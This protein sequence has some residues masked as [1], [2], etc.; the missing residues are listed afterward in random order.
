[1]HD[2][3]QRGFGRNARD[4]PAHLF[5]SAMS[6]GYNPPGT[7][8]GTLGSGEE[9]GNAPDFAAANMIGWLAFAISFI[10]PLPCW[11]FMC[12]FKKYKK[13]PAFGKPI[14]GIY[15]LGF[16]WLAVILISIVV[17]IIIAVSE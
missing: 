7:F 15:I 16:V 5:Q 10:S 14:R 1:L 8:T 17:S 12:A 11:M 4:N 6:A 3:L 13:H 9:S 2:D